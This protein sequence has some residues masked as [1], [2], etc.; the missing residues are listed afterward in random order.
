[1]QYHEL[2]N[3][4][5]EHAQ[6]PANEPQ[7]NG[8]EVW[9]IRLIQGFHGLN[10]G[11]LYVAIFPYF[12]LLGLDRR[13]IGALMSAS[14]LANAFLCYF[15]PQW[16][17]RITHKTLV[18]ATH[19]V[20][21]LYGTVLSVTRHRWAAVPAISGCMV[22]WGHELGFLRTLEGDVLSATTSKNKH[23]E[24]RVFSL[25]LQTSGMLLGMVATA[26]ILYSVSD[27]LPKN[28]PPFAFA[29]KTFTVLELVILLL[30]CLLD[31]TTQ[32]E[33]VSTQEPEDDEEISMKN[34][35]SRYIFC[36]TWAFFFQAVGEGMVLIPWKVDYIYAITKDSFG[37]PFLVAWVLLGDQFSPLLSIALTYLMQ[38]PIKSVIAMEVVTAIVYIGVGSSQSDTTKRLIAISLWTSSRLYFVPAMVVGLVSSKNCTKERSSR[39]SVYRAFGLCLGPLVAGVLTYYDLY[40][41]CYYTSA[42]L[43]LLCCALWATCLPL[44]K[45]LRSPL[46]KFI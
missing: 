21:V 20:T 32:A 22:S 7:L 18:L 15:I 11:L 8:R 24:E 30:V 26:I 46:K 16:H 1:M 9:K 44:D 36:L 2:Q 5:D 13:S 40:G 43:L 29:F 19:T 45:N 41:Y 42:A 31:F 23:F 35:D 37:S 34:G 17:E 33:Q 3:L 38:G 25:I 10:L 27:E 12:E 28:P 6:A 4:E 14:L 39:L